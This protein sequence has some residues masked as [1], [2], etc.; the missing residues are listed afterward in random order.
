M[1]VGPSGS[2]QKGRFRFFLN[3]FGEKQ[4]PEK[5]LEKVLRHEK[6]SENLENFRKI[7]RDR[8]RHEQSK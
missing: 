2:A 8:L 7:P 4:I 1:Q 3:I 6:Y 5:I